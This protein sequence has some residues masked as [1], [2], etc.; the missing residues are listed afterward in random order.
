MIPYK[1]DNPTSHFPFVTIAIILI[2]SIVFFLVPSSGEAGKEAVYA[3]GAIPIYI[4][5]FQGAQPIHPFLT[6]FTSMFM[7]GSIL[8]LLGNM[9]YLWIFGDNIEDR[10]GHVR[11]IIFYLI[12]GIVAAYSYAITDPASKIPMI[13]ASGA[14]SGVLGAYLLLFP[15]AKVHALIFL[16]FFVTVIK[17]PAILVIGF[18]AVIQFLSGLLSTGLHAQGGI[19][20]FAHVGG[21]LWGLIT[22]RLFMM[23]K[24]RYNW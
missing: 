24:R 10:L 18:W 4:M 12:C 11:F 23:R 20:W 19:A 13:G 5:S 21:F 17:I 2:N 6:V 1:D 16:G 14:I 9:L 3:Y 22:I 7:H 8:H 15:K